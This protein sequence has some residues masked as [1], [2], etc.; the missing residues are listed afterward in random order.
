MD[1]FLTEM[2]PFRPTKD[3]GSSLVENVY[4]WNKLANMLYLESPRDIGYSYRDKTAPKDTLYNDDKTAVDNVLALQAFFARFPEYKN[5]DFYVTGESYGGVYVPTLTNLLVKMIQNGTLPYVKLIGMAV[6]NG[7]LNRMDLVNSGLDLVYYRGIIGKSEFDAMQECCQAPQELSA[8]LQMCNFSQ[9]VNIDDYGN[10]VVVNYTDPVKL[11]CSQR[12]VKYGQDLVWSTLNNVYNTWADCYTQSPDSMDMGEKLE[13]LVRQHP[14][15]KLFA[16]S[17]DYQMFSNGQNPFVDQGSQGTSTSTD[18]VGGFSC[19]AQAAATAYMNRQ[20][21]KKAL[22]IPDGLPAWQLCND[23][24]NAIYYKQQH[25]DMMPVFQEMFDSGYPLR[26]LIYNG[27]ADMACQFMG[28]QWFIERFIA[29][30]MIPT[31]SLRQVWNY[32]RTTDF[33]PRIGGFAKTFAL[34][35]MTVDLLTVRGAGHMVPTDRPGPAFQMLQ[36]YLGKSNYTSIASI[37]YAPKPLLPQY[38]PPPTKT[39]T[40][41]Q[42]DRVWDLPGI[43][44]NL[45]FKQ[46]SGYLSGVAG[47]YLHYWLVESQ[48][49]PK[50]DPL[51]LW[52]NGGPGCSS[53]G[54]MLTELGPFH[55]NPDGKTLFENVFSWNKVANVLFLEGPRNVGFSVQNRS[56]NPDEDYNDDRTAND[57]YLA[58]KDFLTAY[59][60]YVNRPFYVTGESYGGVYVPTLT[61]LLIDKIQSGDLVGLNLAGMAVGNGELSALKQVNSI[62]SMLYFHGIYGKSDYDQLQ[63]CCNNTGDPTWFEYC[64]F[65]QFIT[66]DSAGNAQAKVANDPCGTQ[67]ADLG[68]MRVWTSIND[69]YNIY[70]DCYQTTSTML[71]TRMFRPHKEAIQRHLEQKVFVDQ[72]FAIFSY[73]INDIYMQQHNDTG[74]VFDH[75]VKSGYPLRMLIYNGDVDQACNFLGDQ[76]FVEELATRQNFA[77]AKARKEWRYMA[78]IAGYVK[79]FSYGSG[80]IDVL[81]VKGAGH[82]V[83]TDRPGPALQMIAN[84][85]RGQDYSNKLIVS[86]SLTSLT[87]GYQNAERTA[88]ASNYSAPTVTRPKSPISA[89]YG[90]KMDMHLGAAKAARGVKLELPILD[91]PPP[92]PTTRDQDRIDASQLPGLTFTPTFQMYSGYLDASKGNHL[93]YWYV[94]SQNQPSTDPIVLWLNGGPGC[95]SLGGF[96][97]E[98][99]PLRNNPDGTTLFENIYAWNKYANVLFLEAPRGVGFSYRSNDV[100]PDTMYNDT[101]TAND[102]VLGLASFFQ[103]FTDLQNRPFYI[104]GESYGGVYIPTLTDALIKGIQAGTYSYIKL[105]GVAIGNGILSEIKQINSAVSLT[106]FKGLH[107]KA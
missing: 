20:D 32:T 58:L 77:V 86:K 25:P 46:Y 83:P 102:N 24:I 104:T 54:G 91:I 27:D 29:K 44:Y 71:G 31:T 5:R 39:W 96:F 43:T 55:P 51:V 100:D 61:S 85:L 98:L 14:Y 65:S 9:Y 95:S 35:N 52:L 3:N 13:Q 94:E 57:N 75:I 15:L 40:R 72:G 17:I 22:H 38:Q 23:D 6:G 49:N 74:S 76:W 30:N 63:K 37:D 105:A 4:S 11:R 47:N 48:G 87:R 28:D 80:S 64:D 89:H 45:N 50:T 107:D 106:Y 8:P 97:Q 62:I 81:T 41:K 68:Q 16:N 7:A 19:Y 1:G 34:N 88:Q 92:A 18:S 33:M 99:G 70:Q 101:Y 90:K 73:T 42:A 56:I 84:F 82:F 66:L 69:V 93:F 26:F 10:A 78:Q 103:K 12:T 79:Q 59:P 36:N 2:G 60:E 53:L 21:V 67:V